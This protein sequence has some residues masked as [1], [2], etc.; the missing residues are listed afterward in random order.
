VVALLILLLMGIL[1]MMLDIVIWV[2]AIA[3]VESCRW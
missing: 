1:R 2:I 3:R